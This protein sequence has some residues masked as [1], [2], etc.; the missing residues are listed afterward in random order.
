LQD[1]RAGAS[2]AGCRELTRERSATANARDGPRTLPKLSIRGD[3]ADVVAARASFGGLVHQAIVRALREGADDLDVAE[4]PL[5]PGRR[6]V[7]HDDGAC[8]VPL[9]PCLTELDELI[10]WNVRPQRP[11]DVLGVDEDEWPN[12]PG[13]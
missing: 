1:L 4:L 13:R 9:R 7:E 12:R 6:A 11:A 3:E 8:S 5:S 2:S 10:A